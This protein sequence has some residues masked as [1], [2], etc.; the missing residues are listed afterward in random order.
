MA[1]LLPDKSINVYVRDIIQFRGKFFG[2]NDLAWS[3]SL[4]S[5]WQM[6]L[7]YTGG[8]GTTPLLLHSF[9]P[10]FLSF[11]VVCLGEECVPLGILLCR[12][13]KTRGFNAG[14]LSKNARIVR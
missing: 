7:L 13:L 3:L 6:Q 12:Q 11:L 5:P 9:L 4:S 2:Q 1:L 10:C 8:S 14:L